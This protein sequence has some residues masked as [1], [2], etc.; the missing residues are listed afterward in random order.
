MFDI[1]TSFSCSWSWSWSWSL[2]HS[3]DAV[4]LIT[5]CFVCAFIIMVNYCVQFRSLFLLRLI[6]IEESSISLPRFLT[7]KSCAHASMRL[8]FLFFQPVFFGKIAQGRACNFEHHHKQVC[9]NKVDNFFSLDFA[10]FCVNNLFWQPTNN[11]LKRGSLSCCHIRSLQYI[12]FIRPLTMNHDDN[13][14]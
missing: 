3:L 2:F 7:Q 4:E 8:L 14:E 1:V 10:G 6:S 5:L 11:E 12:T 9:S 13:C